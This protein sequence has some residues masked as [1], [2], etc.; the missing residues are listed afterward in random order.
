MTR[1]GVAKEKLENLT[2]GV[3]GFLTWYLKESNMMNI[4]FT[5]FLL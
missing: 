5:S 3:T 4:T 2:E 1:T